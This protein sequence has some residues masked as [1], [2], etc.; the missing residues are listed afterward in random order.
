MNPFLTASSAPSMRNFVGFFSTICKIEI[1]QLMLKLQW[2]WHSEEKFA[3]AMKSLQL[4]IEI[5]MKFTR[6]K[7]WNCNETCKVK[8]LKLQW[9]LQ[10]EKFEIAMIFAKWKAWN[11]NLKLKFAKWKVWN[12]KL[13]LQWN[14]QCKKFDRRTANPQKPSPWWQFLLTCTVSS[15]SSRSHSM[16]LKIKEI[17]LVY[18]ASRD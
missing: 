3:I 10:S 1:L 9:N 7:V 12:C 4:Q 16:D 8:S 2:N 13:K 11:W 15:K 5:A 6:W 17:P 14:L 18:V